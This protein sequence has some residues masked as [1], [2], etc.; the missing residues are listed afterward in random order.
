MKYFSTILK[1]LWIGSTMTVPGV[2]GGTMAVITG[3]YEPCIHALN[4]VRKQPKQYL[5]FLCCFGISA[6]LGFLF[7]ARLVTF[8]LEN[9]ASADFVRLFFCAVVLFG[10]PFLIRQAQITH[11]KLSDFFCVACGAMIVF[12]LSSLPFDLF[13]SNSDTISFYLLQIFAGI[14]TAIA[15]ILPGISV[16]HMLYILGLYEIIFKNVYELHLLVLLP[17]L[18][19]TIAGTILSAKILEKLMIYHRQACYMVIIGFVAASL[20]TLLP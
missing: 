7:F 17:F 1:G 5:P 8:L 18:V 14:L 3:I 19:G 4:H 10:I 15:L 13:Q 20:S 16:T 9:E 6:G 2:S 12:L 11:L